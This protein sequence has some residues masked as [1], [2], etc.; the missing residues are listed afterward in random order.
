VRTV[1]E[2]MDY[3]LTPDRL[4]V[5]LDAMKRHQRGA[6]ERVTCGIV[7]ALVRTGLTSPLAWMIRHQAA[8]RSFLGL[9]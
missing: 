9:K 5:A 2:I 3:R 8:A 1:F 4:Q 6:L 7:S